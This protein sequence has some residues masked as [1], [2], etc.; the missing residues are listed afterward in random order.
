LGGGF[1][2]D[3]AAQAFD[4]L[5][6]LLLAAGYEEHVAEEEQPGYGEGGEQVGQV[7]RGLM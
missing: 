2:H 6:H 5:A 1:F 3:L 7:R 4:V